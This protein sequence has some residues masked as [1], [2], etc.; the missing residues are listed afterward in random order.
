MTTDCQPDVAA[1]MCAVRATG[2]I[3]ATM[4]DWSPRFLREPPIQRTVAGSFRTLACAALVL[5]CGAIATQPVHAAGA[6]TI[7]GVVSNQS[8]TPQRP[9]ASAPV[10]LLVRVQGRTVYRVT[11]RTDAHGAFMLQANAQPNGA[12]YA[13]ATR[14]KRIDYAVLLTPQ[15][16]SRPVALPVYDAT[17]SDTG[18]AAMRVTVGAR[19]RGHTLT[20]IQQWVFTNAGSRTDGGIDGVTGRGAASFPLPAGAQHVSVRDVGPQPATAAVRAGNVVVNTIVRPATGLNDAS[21]HQLTVTYDLTSDDDHPTLM[22]PTRYFIGSLKV[23]A[24]G[25]KL[26][27]PDFTTSTLDSGSGTIPALEAKAIA[28][29]TTLAIGVDG[30]PVGATVATPTLAIAS[31]FPSASVAVMIEIGFGVLLLLGILGRNGTA[32]PARL[33]RERAQLVDDIAELDLRCARG[34]VAEAEYGRR[35]TEAKRRLLAVARQL[36]E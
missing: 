22:L 3:R 2:A 24:V 14:Y 9:V 12:I 1:S 31:P 18:M 32:N 34:Q 15:Q 17:T 5:L 19:R 10:E 27:G 29:G 26:F 6:V 23:F 8:T 28:P 11:T 13:I 36:D 33:Q 25:S 21:L 7:R 4:A 35:R 16:F 20:V 30:P